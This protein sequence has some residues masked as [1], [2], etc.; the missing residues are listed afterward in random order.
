MIVPAMTTPMVIALICLV[1]FVGFAVY[2]ALCDLTSF[3]IPDIVSLAIAAAFVIAA[4]VLGLSPMAI[5][6]HLGV[7]LGV[8]AL[9]AALFA[10]GAFGGGDVKMLAAVALWFGP[11][12]TVPMIL[13]VALFGGV[14]TMLQLGGRLLPSE[15]RTASPV[16]ERLVSGSHGVPYGIAIAAGSVT[17]IFAAPHLAGDMLH[18]IVL[19]VMTGRGG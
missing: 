10:F 18:S 3:T 5:L 2:G 11:A 9:G 16:V 17:L 15:M 7:A 1:A 12:G 19:P 13:L 6:A 8:F 4:L 14:V